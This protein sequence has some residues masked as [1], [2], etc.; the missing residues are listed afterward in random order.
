[1]LVAMAPGCIPGCECTTDR[2]F[3]TARITSVEPASPVIADCTNDPVVVMLHFTSEDGDVVLEFSLQ[4]EDLSTPPRAWV[5][6]EGLTVGSVHPAFFDEISGGSCQ[7]MG[8]TLQGV[9][10][11]AARASCFST[12]DPVD[13]GGGGGGAGQGGAGGSDLC[14]M[15]CAEALVEDMPVCPDAPAASIKAYNDLDDCVCSPD[16]MV[17]KCT[18]ACANETCA[19]LPVVNG[20]PCMKCVT[21]IDTQTGCGNQLNACSND[22]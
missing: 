6:G 2:T 18:D 20:S 13:G 19:G 4:F 11:Y 9:N 22:F 7:G 16:P 10:E 14:K 15:T 3:G 12:N 5:E 17:G 8:I 21:T 1:M